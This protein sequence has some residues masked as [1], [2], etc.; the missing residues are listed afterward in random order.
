MFS[1]VDNM[2]GCFWSL[3]LLHLLFLC[4]RRLISEVIWVVSLTEI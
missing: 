1:R 4:F 2:V 3:F